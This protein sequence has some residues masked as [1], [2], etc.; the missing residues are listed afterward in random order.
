MSPY[1][2]AYA[3][4]ETPNPCVECNR[5]MKFGRVLARARA[6]AP[7]LRAKAEKGLIDIGRAASE[8]LYQVSDDDRPEVLLRA[9]SALRQI[10]EFPEELPSDPALRTEIEGQAVRV[11]AALN[12]SY[13]L[14]RRSPANALEAH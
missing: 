5:T 7:K 1:V 2:D 12:Q 8:A 10:E 3:S 4:G 11:D 13:V 14:G 9:A 6:L